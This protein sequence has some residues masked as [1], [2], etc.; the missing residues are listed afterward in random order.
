MT[1]DPGQPEPRSRRPDLTLP[2]VV[3]VAARLVRFEPPPR[4]NFDS[5]LPRLDTTVEFLVETE[6]PIPIR[7]LAP[8]LYVG[9]VAVTEVSADDPT[10]YRFIALRPSDLDDGAPITLG[11]S[12][13]PG[14]ERLATTFRFEPPEGFRVEPPESTGP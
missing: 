10:H 6:E 5:K 2:R 7:A 14:N 11:W 9:E 3:R 13:Q 1:D 4:R 12:G 8:V